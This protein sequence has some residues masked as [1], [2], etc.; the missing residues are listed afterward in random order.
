MRGCCHYWDKKRHF[1]CPRCLGSDI[2]IV[3]WHWQ[4]WK[5]I[6]NFGFPH[7]SSVV[8]IFSCRMN[9]SSVMKFFLATICKR[10][11]IGKPLC[12]DFLSAYVSVLKVGLKV[13][14]HMEI[15]HLR[16]HVWKW[17]L[18]IQELEMKACAA[19]MLLNF[20]F[21]FSPCIVQSLLLSSLFHVL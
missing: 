15:I 21:D 5:C 16:A 12:L 4:Y 13:F 19:L 2:I 8:Y 11:W 18:F 7:T 10:I 3:F 17:R 14:H 9:L 1:Q 20:M 6:K